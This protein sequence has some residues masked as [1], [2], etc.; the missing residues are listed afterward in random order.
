QL[1]RWVVEGE[2]RLKYDEGKADE[3]K[4]IL[5]KLLSDKY[6]NESLSWLDEC[7]FE[8]LDHVFNYIYSNISMNDLKHNILN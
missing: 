8:Q 5:T 6:S 7:S 3:R 4:A 2:K 1:G